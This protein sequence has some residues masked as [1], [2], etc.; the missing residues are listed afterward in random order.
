VSDQDGPA[1]RKQLELAYQQV[2]TSFEGITDFRGKLLALLPL[3]TAGVL[4]TPMEVVYEMT[5]SRSVSI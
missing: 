4:A 1:G 2:C 3:G 5:T